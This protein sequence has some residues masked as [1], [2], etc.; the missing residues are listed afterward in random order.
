MRY[1]GSFKMINS[2]SEESKMCVKT[3]KVREPLL[4]CPLPL[5]MFHVYLVDNMA[6][7]VGNSPKPFG[8]LQLHGEGHPAQKYAAEGE[9]LLPA[10]GFVEGVSPGLAAYMVAAFC[11]ETALSKPM[12]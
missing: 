7:R 9:V 10:H 11:W 1:S 3:D 8:G 4:C 5:P 2:T 12:G 6:H